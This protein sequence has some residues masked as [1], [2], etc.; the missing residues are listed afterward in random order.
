MEDL[1][2]RHLKDAHSGEEQSLPLSGSKNCGRKTPLKKTIK[3]NK[4]SPTLSI[5][6]HTVL[7]SY[8][9]QKLESIHL[10]VIVGDLE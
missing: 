4:N 6:K 9:S 8:F 2:Q 10:L 7:Y 1:I 3:P 5:V